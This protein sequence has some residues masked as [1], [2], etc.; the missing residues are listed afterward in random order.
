M[1]TPASLGRPGDGPAQPTEPT[2]A[3]PVNGYDILDKV[4]TL[5][6]STWRY[7]WEPAG[8]R[9]LGPMAQDWQATFGLGS[10][11]HSIPLVDANGVLLVAI[12]ALHHQVRQLQAEITRLQSP[13]ADDQRI[14][15]RDRPVRARPGGRG[16]S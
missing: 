16:P 14:P 5:P 4:A 7:H 8:I 3:E 1:N 15:A 12:Q 2:T 9:H 10:D 11:G 6:I 13:T